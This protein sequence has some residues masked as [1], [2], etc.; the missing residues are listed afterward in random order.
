[1]A[2]VAGG[3]VTALVAVLGARA[4]GGRVGEVGLAAVGIDAAVVAVGEPGIAHRRGAIDVDGAVAAIRWP[5]A[6][7][8]SG[9][10][11]LLAKSLLGPINLIPQAPRAQKTKEN[12]P[13]RANTHTPLTLP[14][15]PLR[16][17]PL[18]PSEAAV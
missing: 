10:R 17:N 6:D 2:A 4:T 18:T 13:C 3:L 12:Q 5:H 11:R 7:G 14:S 15:R 16:V 9:R 1:D 8:G